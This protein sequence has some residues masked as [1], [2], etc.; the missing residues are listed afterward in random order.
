MKKI[1]LLTFA[2]L[3][4]ALG[5]SLSW[6]QSVSDEF[7][8]F[9]IIADSN[10]PYDQ[11]MKINLRN[12]ILNELSEGLIKCSSKK[13]TLDFLQ[14]N[15]EKCQKLSL[16][17]FEETEYDKKVSVQLSRELFPKKKY[18]AFTLPQGNYHALKIT[19]GSGKGKNYFCVMFPQSCISSE[20]TGKVKKMLNSK[21]I[22]Y[23]FKIPEI[24]KRSS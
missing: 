4:I 5:I 15:L 1:L 24:I 17:F 21:K 19:I 2:V 3:L 7:V 23:K 13:E 18:S 9:H 16:D 20:M 8:R 22:I 11:L 10:S 6:F 12:I 14:N